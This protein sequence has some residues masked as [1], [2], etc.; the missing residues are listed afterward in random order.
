MTNER[1]LVLNNIEWNRHSAVGC[2]ERYESGCWVWWASLQPK[3]E[4]WTDEISG[5]VI[6]TLPTL[7][8]IRCVQRSGRQQ[9]RYNYC[10][11]WQDYAI[12]IAAFRHACFVFPSCHSIW[13]FLRFPCADQK[14]LSSCVN[15]CEQGLRLKEFACLQQGPLAT[16]ID[17]QS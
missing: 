13:L 14:G 9:T 17:L 11:R 15:P 2:P 6:I 8:N 4:L 16:S 5:S 7:I 3:V 10:G 1:L 12:T